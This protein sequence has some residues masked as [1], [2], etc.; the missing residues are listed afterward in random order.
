MMRV[1]I[2]SMRGHSVLARPRRTAGR[3]EGAAGRADGAGRSA[4]VDLDRDG[5]AVRDHVEHGGPL[6]GLLD[7]LT[8]LLRIVALDGEPDADLLVPIADIG[9]EAEDAEQVDV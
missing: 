9:G 1:S 5:N 4:G 7:D 6:P 3:R 2:V 8:Q